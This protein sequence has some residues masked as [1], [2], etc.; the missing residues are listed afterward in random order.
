M[1]YY[2]NIKQSKAKRGLHSLINNSF[3]IFLIILLSFILSFLVSCN[4][5]DKT[6][7]SDNGGV[8]VGVDNVNTDNGTSGG[9]GSNGGDSSSAAGGSSG[10]SSGSSSG[11]DSSDDSGSG[12]S[13]SGEESSGEIAGTTSG[14]TGSGKKSD[15][16]G[17]WSGYNCSF[18][19]TNGK[20]SMSLFWGPTYEGQI[21]DSF[22]YPFSILATGTLNGETKT[23]IFTFYSATNGAYYYYNASGSRL[24][25][26]IEKKGSSGS[27]GSSSGEVSSS[28]ITNYGSSTS[29]GVKSEL[30]GKWYA[31]YDNFNIT[32]GKLSMSSS[33]PTYEGQIPNSFNYPLNI[34]L[35]GTYSGKTKTAIFTFYSATNGTCY[36]YRFDSTSS[37]WTT[38]FIGDS[39]KLKN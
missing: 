9:S 2:I 30:T 8:G 27:G 23:G 19:I 21:P 39:Y 34:V 14:S 6:G 32:D 36:Y 15:L 29:C 35:T 4:N 26:N 13:G 24:L 17:E 22:N 1:I 3:K 11:G 25:G 5:K 38:S 31:G 16:E 7:G 37:S 12:D 10:S 18:G 20:L 28:G 33:T